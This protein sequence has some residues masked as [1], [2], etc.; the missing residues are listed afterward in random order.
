VESQSH[1][2][3]ATDSESVECS[4][5]RNRGAQTGSADVVKSVDRVGDLLSAAR[6]ISSRQIMTGGKG[7]TG[8][9]DHYTLDQVPGAIVLHQVGKLVQH[10]GVQCIEFVRPVEA[11]DCDVIG[12]RMLYQ[13][14]CVRGRHQRCSFLEELWTGR[15]IVKIPGP[16]VAR[17]AG[18]WLLIMRSEGVRGNVSTKAIS[19]GSLKR[20]R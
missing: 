2:E 18:I 5:C 4:D 13:V 17:P 16:S 15:G 11:D 20:A 14:L 3:R 1:L 12:D 9:R 6:L 10:A 19:A 7:A 8:T